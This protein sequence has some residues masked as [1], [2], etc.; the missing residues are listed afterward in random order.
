MII[1]VYFSKSS[2]SPVEKP[3]EHIRDARQEDSRISDRSVSPVTSGHLRPY[4]CVFH[5]IKK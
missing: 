1:Y 5:N 4:K 3:I 2:A